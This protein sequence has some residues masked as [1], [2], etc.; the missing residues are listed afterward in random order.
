MLNLVDILECETTQE[1]RVFALIALGT[2]DGG[3]LLYVV[4]T[5]QISLSLP[6]AALANSPDSRSFSLILAVATWVLL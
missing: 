5:E 2:R 6:V 4:T 3:G 1:E